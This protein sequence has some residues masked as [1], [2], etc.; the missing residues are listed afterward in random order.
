MSVLPKNLLMLGARFQMAR[1]AMELRQKKSAVPAQQRTFLRLMK[2]FARTEYGRT[3]GLGPGL[4]Y[5]SFQKRVPLQTYEKIGPFVDRMKRGE[6]DVLWPGQ[7]SFYAVT[8]GS[9]DGP[10]KSLPVTFDLLA[11]FRQASRDA[12]LYYCAQVGHMRVFDGRHVFLG[13]ASPLSLI[14]ESAPFTAYEGDISALTALNLPSWASR[15][16]YEPGADIDQLA[17]WPEK[18][19]AIAKRTRSLNVSMVAGIPSW[20]LLLAEALRPGGSRAPTGSRPPSL[21]TLWP[22]LECLMHAGVPLGPYQAELRRAFGPTVN[23]HEV[24]PTTE[25]FI[26][27]QDASAPEGLRLMA[28]AG[29]FFEFLPLREFDANR[30]DAIAAR[31]VPLEGV[32]ANEDYALLLTTPAGLCRYVLGD[33]VRFISTEPHRLIYTGRTGLPM[34]AF[35]E[36]VIEKELTDALLAVC[37]PHGWTITNFHVAPS[38]NET[39]TGNNRGRHEWWVELKPGSIETPTGPQLAAQLDAELRSRNPYYESRRRGVGLEAP[40]ARLVMPGVFEHWMRHHGK[41]G[42]LHK[43]PRCRSDRIIADELMAI[44]RFNE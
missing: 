14:P 35:E 32:K 11:H 31:A 29:L 5:S 8:P 18:V 13:G 30:L 39:H 44:A 37:S 16:F 40:V 24:Y 1:T 10:Q 9:T 23:F 28:D 21:Q 26:A 43:M 19:A 42:G 6:A 25:G 17:D 12:L 3:H 4:S 2:Q 15:H 38:F 33:V 27:A 22:N 41:W 34:N 7:C 36:R 20:L